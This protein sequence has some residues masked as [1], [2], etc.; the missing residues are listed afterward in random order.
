MAG[1][2]T[3]PTPYAK[4]SDRQV[5][6]E[7]ALSLRVK[8]RDAGRRFWVR[9]ATSRPQPQLRSLL[10]LIA[11][12][13]S[14]LLIIG[15]EYA[16]FPIAIVVH[17]ALSASLIPALFAASFARMSARD[18]LRLRAVG[19]RSMN[20]YPGVERILNSLDER[21]IRERVRISCSILATV[22]LASLWNLDAGETLSSIVLGV[23]IALSVI[24]ALN[25]QQL[26]ATIP[27]RS[28][29]FPLLS[30]HAPTLHDSTLDRVLSDLLVAHLDP[31]TASHWD[32]WIKSLVHDVRS[33]QTPDSAVEHLLQ[34]IHLEHLGL[35]DDNGLLSETRRVFKVSAID[36]LFSS[37]SKFNMITLRRLLAHTRAW[38]PGLFRLTDRLQDSVIRGDPSLTEAVWRLDLD[39]PPRCGQGQGNLFVMIHNHSGKNQAIEVNILA[40][41]GEPEIQNL[42]VFAKASP[43]PKSPI[44][45]GEERGALTQSFGRLLSDSTVLWI[46]LA[47]PDSISGPHPVQV[48][49]RD[50]EGE[51]L[52]SFVV[53]TILSSGVQAESMGHRMA[54]AAS[55]VRRIALALTD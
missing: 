7:Q 19:F 17:V 4:E 30:L 35:L 50:E 31:E 53:T 18:R 45:V 27:M 36:G 42:R 11:P 6:Q 10:S 44:S 5:Q 9:I 37:T 32:I 26:E 20:S 29:S 55:E 24:C 39:L 1:E 22:A 16:S 3:L 41:A 34:A 47:W 40:A 25:T 28:N 38:Q 33:D 8:A 12:I 49:L 21:R 46:G 51:T 15:W 13:T 52:E 14:A 54:D 23:C 48:T 2:R 43:Q